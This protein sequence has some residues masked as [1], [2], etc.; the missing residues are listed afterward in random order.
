LLVNVQREQRP[1][2]DGTQQSAKIF[3]DFSSSFR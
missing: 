3:P 1:E 2:P